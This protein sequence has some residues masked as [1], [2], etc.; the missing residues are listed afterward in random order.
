MTGLIIKIALALAALA[1]GIWLGLPGRYTQTVQEIDEVMDR[2]GGQRRNVKR[3][4]TPVAW[5]QRN[6][7]VRSGA[8]K[9]RGRS[10]FKVKSPDER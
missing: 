7:S 2:G 6:L 10:G 1:W 9:Q 5:M 8:G 4:F 3:R